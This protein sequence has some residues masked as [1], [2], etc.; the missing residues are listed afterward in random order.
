[1]LHN[2]SLKCSTEYWG[3]GEWRLARNHYGHLAVGPLEQGKYVP[4]S[5]RNGGSS[6]RLVEEKTSE[7]LM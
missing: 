6:Y 3:N 4:V 2:S 5:T 1:V 7:K